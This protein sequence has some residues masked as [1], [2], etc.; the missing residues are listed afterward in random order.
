M[1][2]LLMQRGASISH[3]FNPSPLK[4]MICVPVPTHAGG[5]PAAWSAAACA[6]FCIVPPRGRAIPRLYA[7]T[8]S[9]AEW[10]LCIL[11]V[12]GSW[13]GGEFA[14]RGVAC[15]GSA[16]YGQDLASKVIRTQ[17]KLGFCLAS[18]HWWQAL[19]LASSCSESLNSFSL[20]LVLPHQGCL[21]LNDPKRR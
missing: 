21:E 10:T 19:P 18:V 13:A 4:R 7:L 17:G 14:R 5:G 15:Q 12:V 20:R 3:L 11:D 6:P 9:C 8:G 16:W 1:L 2:L